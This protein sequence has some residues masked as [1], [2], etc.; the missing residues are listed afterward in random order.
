MCVNLPEIVREVSEE[1]QYPQSVVNEILRKSFQT[2]NS[3]LETGHS[4]RIFGF[5]TFFLSQHG[6]KIN[7]SS[8][9]KMG[10]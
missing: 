4:V 1:T 3:R 6:S 2:M 10:G 5:G 7:F 8:N 9:L